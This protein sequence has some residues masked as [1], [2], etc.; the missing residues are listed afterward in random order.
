MALKTL[1]REELS[2]LW[3]CFRK[4]ELF[5]MLTATDIVIRVNEIIEIQLQTI[6]TNPH[7]QRFQIQIP[8]SKS[9]IMQRVYHLQQLYPN[10]THSLQRKHLTIAS[11]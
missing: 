7:L 11:H 1:C 8:M 9:F 2:W 10:L 4:L 3:T 5:D 6:R